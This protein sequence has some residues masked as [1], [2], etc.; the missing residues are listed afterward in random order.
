MLLFL[1][2][3]LLFVLNPGVIMA[4]TIEY[5]PA[6]WR[7]ERTR[8]ELKSRLIRNNTAEDVM[9]LEVELEV[10]GFVQIERNM[11]G[12]NMRMHYCA[13]VCNKVNLPSNHKCMQLEWY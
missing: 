12:Y 2:S 7:R 1:V 9:R 3:C 13:S 5:Q 10:L 11:A 6:A 4:P 8:R